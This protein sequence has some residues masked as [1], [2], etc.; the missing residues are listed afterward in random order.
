METHADGDSIIDGITAIT[1]TGP[2]VIKAAG[3]GMGGTSMN[4]SEWFHFVYLCLFIIIIIVIIIII[5]KA[6]AHG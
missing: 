6:A 2:V 3:H 5:I 4:G 1:T